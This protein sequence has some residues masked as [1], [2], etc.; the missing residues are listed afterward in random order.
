M[1]LSTCYQGKVKWFSNKA[2]YGFITV[3]KD[4]DKK[5]DDAPSDLPETLVNE[6]IFIHH[7]GITTEKQVYKFLQQ[8]EMVVFKILF[9]S[10]S[11]HKYQ[12]IEVTGNGTSLKCENPKPYERRQRKR[13]RSRSGAN[14]A[15]A[16]AEE[17]SP[18]APPP[19]PTAN[20]FPVLASPNATV[21]GD[22][23]LCKLTA[24]ASAAT[25]SAAAAVAA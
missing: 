4:A 20:D 5:P 10:T 25:V 15:D 9:L 8:D 14:G 23:D 24:T 3:T 19:L 1:D 11:K 2:G 13:P 7:T 22:N 21:T 12:A 17:S 16:A 6:D 18:P